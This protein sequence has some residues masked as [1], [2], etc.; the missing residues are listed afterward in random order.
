VRDD[1]RRVDP[2][3]LNDD[4]LQRVPLRRERQRVEILDLVAD[5]QLHR[6]ADLAHEHL[7]EFPGDWCVRCAVVAALDSSADPQLRRRAGELSGR[8]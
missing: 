8:G 2:R 4:S 1:D 3:P 5:H 6:A 7:A